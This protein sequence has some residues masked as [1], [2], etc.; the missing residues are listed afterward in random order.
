MAH[1]IRNV[2]LRDSLLAAATKPRSLFYLS[3][4]RPRRRVK[5]TCIET[6]DTR[7][8]IVRSIITS[9]KVACG[10]H[11]T[12]IFD[13]VNPLDIASCYDKLRTLVC[14]WSILPVHRERFLNHFKFCSDCLIIS[15]ACMVV[16]N[17]FKYSTTLEWYRDLQKIGLYL[18]LYTRHMYGNGVKRK[19]IWLYSSK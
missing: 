18:L 1:C 11:E 5:V 2:Y 14:Y 12:S 4:M 17:R 7:Y 19:C 6:A 9:T 16:Y 3:F 8:D 15:W 13:L 10:S